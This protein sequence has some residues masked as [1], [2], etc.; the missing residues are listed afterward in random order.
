MCATP[1]IRSEDGRTEIL[2]PMIGKSKFKDEYEVSVVQTHVQG[3]KVVMCVSE[4][5]NFPTQKGS[6]RM[7]RPLSSW[8]AEQ[9]ASCRFVT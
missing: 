6:F 8:Q 9:A 5:V 7:I 1:L 3:C 2:I 4:T